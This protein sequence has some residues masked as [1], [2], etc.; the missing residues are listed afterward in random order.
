MR[1]ACFTRLGLLPSIELETMLAS[2]P[3]HA[4][5]FVLPPWEVI[6]V[7]DAER[8]QS[9]AEAVDVHA[10]VVRGAVRAAMFSMKCPAF[11]LPREPSMCCASSGRAPPNPQSLDSL[12]FSKWPADAAQVLILALIGPLLSWL[13]GGQKPDR[14]PRRKFHNSGRSVSPLP[15]SSV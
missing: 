8:D 4:A 1:W 9:F 2:Y 7:N 10:K 6:Y 5:V 3:F 13:S 15:I 12:T 14:R 11:R